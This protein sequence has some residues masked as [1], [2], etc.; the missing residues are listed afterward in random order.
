MTAIDVVV[1]GLQ[2][3]PILAKVLRV[4]IRELPGSGIVVDKVMKPENRLVFEGWRREQTDTT[5]AR[6]RARTEIAENRLRMA[7]QRCRSNH[8]LITKMETVDPSP[9]AMAQ[10]L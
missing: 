10:M 5:M 6:N 2:K 7:R 3:R 8:T 1:M 4:G 9:I